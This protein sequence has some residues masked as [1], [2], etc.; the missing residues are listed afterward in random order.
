MGETD[1]SEQKTAALPP[2]IEGETRVPTNPGV[3]PKDGPV[4]SAPVSPLPI[5]A[6]PPSRPS[7]Q[8]IPRP[9]PDD[10]RPPDETT[11]AV[12]AAVAA[13]PPAQAVA[14]PAKAPSVPPRAP[15]R[16]SR[17]EILDPR[18]P[19]STGPLGAYEA[20]AR[21]ARLPDLIDVAR[22]VLGDA[23]AKRQADFR[24]ARKAAEEARLSRVDADTL[25]G[26]AL[27]VLEEGPE[28][29]MERALACAL[30]AH[31]VAEMPRKTAEDEDKIAG[32]LLWL[33]THTAFDAIPLLV[34]ALGEDDANDVFA[35]IADRVR[36]AGKTRTAR[37]EAIVGAAALASGPSLRARDLARDLGRDMEDPVLARVLGAVSS[38]AGEEVRLEGEMVPTPRGPIATTL[39]ALTGILFVANGVR[40]AARIALAYK[41]PAEVLLSDAGVRIKTRTEMLGRTLREHEHVIAKNGL[42]RVAREVRYPRLAFYAGLLA[43]ALGSCVGVRTLAD[44]VR[45]ASPSL[46][47]VGLVIIA[48]GIAIDFVL[49]TLVPGSKGKVRIA[50]FP[51]SGRALTVGHVDARRADE[52]LSRALGR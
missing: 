28:G 11:T 35:A 10:P 49:L 48:V 17:S 7:P 39:L 31:C 41:R 1:R 40:L 46:L 29:E 22:K 34:R 16:P 3:G 26:N 14:A 8:E 43:L 45:A 18:A 32:D 23:V 6:P 42:T 36:R 33:A 4:E 38:P 12:N 50:F 24:G 5:A 25:Y 9:P 37:A 52:A 13:P 44:G 20:L 2:A 47:V 19:V 15:S 21:A 51:K 30:A 27:K